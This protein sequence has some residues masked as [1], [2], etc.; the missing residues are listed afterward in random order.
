MYQSVPVI[1][2]V[3]LS[4]SSSVYFHLTSDK[5]LSYLNQ[6]HLAAL[7]LRSHHLAR[8]NFHLPHSSSFQLA[9]LLFIYLEYLSSSNC[10][11]RKLESE[12]SHIV[13]QDGSCLVLVV[14][15]TVVVLVF[16]FRVS[17]L[18][19]PISRFPSPAQAS[20]QHCQLAEKLRAMNCHQSI[21]CE[22][23]DYE[24]VCV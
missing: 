15:G 17:R 1:L 6:P 14:V 7:H 19:S 16:A 9:P 2:S 12:F 4:F 21:Y 22:R 20:W 3:R 8:S 13:A 24:T 11:D 5:K 18:P 23:T 10:L